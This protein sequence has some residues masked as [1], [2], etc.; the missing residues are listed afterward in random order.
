MRE[1]MRGASEHAKETSHVV[2]SHQ[3]SFLENYMINQGVRQ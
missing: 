1:E 3:E 2:K